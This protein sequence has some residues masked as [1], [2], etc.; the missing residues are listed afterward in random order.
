[1][2]LIP[3]TD[4]DLLKFGVQAGLVNKLNKELVH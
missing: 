1:M 2:S 3:Q 4:I